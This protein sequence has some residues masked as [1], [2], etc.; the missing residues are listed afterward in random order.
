M[1][2]FDRLNPQQLNA[3]RKTELLLF[4]PT[5][6]EV[7][8]NTDAIEPGKDS[9]SIGPVLPAEMTKAPFRPKVAGRIAFFLGP[10]AGALISVINLRR[11]GYPLK[12]KRVFFWT[13]VGT[14]ALAVVFLSIPDVLGR[15]VGL[16][17]EIAF[18]QVYPRLQEKEFGE[19]QIAHAEI[20]PL[21]GWKAIGWSFAGLLLFLVVFFAVGFP[22]SILFPAAR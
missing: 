20:E 2:R 6:R 14:A 11:F 10:V 9:Y 21:S 16:A 15:V 12:A 22:L 13:L 4:C 1:A 5:T 19:W 7:L 8:I 18:Y 17:A 3:C